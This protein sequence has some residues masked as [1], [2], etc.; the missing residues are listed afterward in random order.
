MV[1]QSKSTAHSD[2]RTIL[3]VLLVSLGMVGGAVAAVAGLWLWFD[4]QASP[5]NSF[6]ALF[7]GWLVSLLPV[8]AQSYLTRQTQVMGLP[9][10]AHTSAY[11]YMARA[12]G[13]TAYLL[14][15][16]STVWGLLLSTKVAP[17]RVPPSLAYGIH[18][19]LSI[20]T[21]LFAVLHATVLLGD[22][23]INFNVFHL[24]VPFIAPY[25][26]LWTGLGTI[27]LYLTVA[28]VASFYLRKHIGQ[29]AWRMFHYLTFGAYLLALLHGIKAGSDSDLLV[30]MLLYW[31]TGFSVLF[32]TELSIYRHLQKHFKWK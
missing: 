6:L 14:L 21:V 22:S 5:D 4:Y 1:S 24:A 25:E 2:L 28:L 18:E 15:W 30:S 32:L 17:K 7:S 3:D 9:L 11:W 23:Y 27:G 10:T 20:L 29:R 8:T 31:V 12:G 13:I 26:P 16:A 19:Y